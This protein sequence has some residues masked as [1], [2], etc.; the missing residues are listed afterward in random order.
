VS[1]PEELT[2]DELIVSP[3]TNPA[4]QWVKVQALFDRI[5]H[6]ESVIQA[7]PHGSPDCQV[8]WNPVTLMW[9][10]DVCDCWKSKA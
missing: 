7:A 3:S 5:A 10:H 1:E 4:M 8:R 2:G 9:E 6:L